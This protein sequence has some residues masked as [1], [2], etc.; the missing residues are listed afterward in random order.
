L[1]QIKATDPLGGDTDRNLLLDGWKNF[2][3]LRT[4][5][6]FTF[7]GS[8]C[9]GGGWGEDQ[10]LNGIRDQDSDGNWVETDFLA[11]D[12]D[13][14]GILDG[15]EV[16]GRWCYKTETPGQCD[17]KNHTGRQLWIN[18]SGETPATNGALTA[19]WD[20]DGLRD[21]QEIAGWMVGIWYERTMEKKINYSVTSDPKAVNS[22]SDAL[23]DF[24]EFM[25]ASDPR[26]LDTDGDH[27]NDTRE[28]EMGSNLTGIEGPLRAS[29]CG[30]LP[31]RAL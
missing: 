6:C 24:E 26:A 8:Q 16:W 14:D 25:N 28:A 9:L 27:I 12:S 19:D 15:T 7:G 31:E 11:N 10:N 13:V 20:A 3:T 23:T 30:S 5:P 2:G 21:G 17:A 22:D 1:A 29:I 18:Q 4:S